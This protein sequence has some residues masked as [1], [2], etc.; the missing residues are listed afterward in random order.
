MIYRLLKNGIPVAIAHS[1]EEAD[2]L[3]QQYDCD[4]CK[5]WND[6]NASQTEEHKK[7]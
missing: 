3:Y 7:E 5:G 6:E 2:K 4:E 1:P